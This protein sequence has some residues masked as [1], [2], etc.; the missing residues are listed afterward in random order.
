MV[1]DTINIFIETQFN[2]DFGRT[3]VIEDEIKVIIL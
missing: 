2:T 3:E 1:G